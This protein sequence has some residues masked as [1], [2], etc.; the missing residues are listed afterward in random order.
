MT[1]L[2][3]FAKAQSKWDKD[4]VVTYKMTDKSNKLLNYIVIKKDTL[5][6]EWSDKEKPKKKTVVM[7][8]ELENKILNAISDN[9]VLKFKSA[10]L[11]KDSQNMM[12]TH[13]RGKKTKGV[14]FSQPIKKGSREEKFIK[15]FM[16]P[17]V[18]KVFEDELKNF[19]K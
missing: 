15:E 14:V 1:C 7:D 8:L 17:I 3:V 13:T 19:P 10:A 16:E 4:L 11:T 12:F 9:K 18:L 5:V 2:I 6:Y